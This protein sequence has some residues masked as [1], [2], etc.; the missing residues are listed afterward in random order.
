MGDAVQ[1]GCGHFLVCEHLHP[2]AEVEVGGDDQ[3]GFL[4]QLAD[5]MEQQRA[6]GF[7]ES[8]PHFMPV[9][10]SAPDPERTHCT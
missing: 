10:R 5:Q 9:K 1:Q 8:G 2:F 4:V 7:G 6:A 3:A